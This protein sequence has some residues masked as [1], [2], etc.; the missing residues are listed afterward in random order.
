MV[1]AGGVVRDRLKLPIWGG[2]LLI[3][4]VLLWLGARGLQAVF[5]SARQGSTPATSLTIVPNAPPDLQV[6]LT[7]DSDVADTGR[8]MEPFTRLTIQ[9]AYL[10]A[11][12]Q[13]N[14]SYLK[15]APYGLSTYF[16]GTA[17]T[18]VEASV[19]QAAA[20]RLSVEQA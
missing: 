14:L 11:W 16:T 19:T 18:N 9:S 2:I 20:D 17:L 5:S 10:R 8:T 6:A 1:R 3:G 12:L 15:G 4:V 13:W 7:W